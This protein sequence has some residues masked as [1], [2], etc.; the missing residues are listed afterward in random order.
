MD[1]THIAVGTVRC[2]ELTCRAPM[3]RQTNRRDGSEFFGCCRF[4]VCRE[5]REIPEHVLLTERGAEQLPGF[6]S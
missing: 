1:M 2:P 5:T 3:I 4:P 6:D